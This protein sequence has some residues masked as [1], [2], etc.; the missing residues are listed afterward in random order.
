MGFLVNSFIE[1][2]APT[3]D[4]DSVS[5]LVHWYDVSDSST[6]TKDGSNL[7]SNIA[8]KKG[9]S[10][11]VQ[12]TGSSQPSWISG[13]Q[14]GLDTMSIVSGKSIHTPSFATV[15]KP[16]FQFFVMK[17]P[18]NTGGNQQLLSQDV[19]TGM[20]FY[21]QASNVFSML[22][23][24]SVSVTVSITQKWVMV[25]FDGTEGSG[26]ASLQVDGTKA[27]G[28]TSATDINLVSCLGSATAWELGEMLLYSSALSSD[29][30][31]EI[32]DYL[33]SKWDVT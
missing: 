19:V 14:N 20:D 17:T 16:L 7:I 18:P 8:D 5:G 15:A 25:V 27:T 32:K 21:R 1:F 3:F 12:A 9:S 24:S 31:T 4:P 22:S 28:T 2:P 10:P 26:N 13:G 29:D 11:F 33:T 6:V 23:T 30:Q